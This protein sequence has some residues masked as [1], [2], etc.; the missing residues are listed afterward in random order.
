MAHFDIHRNLDQSTRK[1]T[2]FLLDV[3]SDVMSVLETRLV[4]PV[5]PFQQAGDHAISRLHPAFTINNETFT[6]FVTEMAGVPRRLLGEIVQSAAGDRS[7][8]I[9]AIDLLIS[10]F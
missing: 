3:Q 10:G 9:A 2:P 4:I 7:T 5:R 6:A 8:I 1:E